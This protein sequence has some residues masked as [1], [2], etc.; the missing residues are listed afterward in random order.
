M[1]N[2]CKYNP[3]Q[4]DDCSKQWQLLKQYLQTVLNHEYNATKS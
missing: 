2:A 1:Y 4:A 3:L